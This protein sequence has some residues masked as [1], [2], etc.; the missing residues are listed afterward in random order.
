[1]KELLIQFIVPLTF[2]AIW[3]LTSILNRDGQPLPQRP[4]RPGDRPLDPAA[5]ARRQRERARAEREGEPWEADDASPS[6]APSRPDPRR[7][8]ATTPGR[9][10][11]SSKPNGGRPRPAPPQ[12]VPSGFDGAGVYVN[13]DEVVFLDPGTGRRLLSAPIEAEPSAEPRNPAAAPPRQRKAGRARREQRDGARQAPLEPETRRALSDQVGQAMGM[14]R[15]Q[16]LE[17]KPL[18]PKLE[19]LSVSLSKPV[20]LGDDH[21]PAA[22]PRPAIDAR[23]IQEMFAEARKLREV[24]VLSEILQPP[25]SLRRRRF[26]RDGR[27]GRGR[28]G[29]RPS[30]IARP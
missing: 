2:L 4:R 25:V 18:A 14:R 20:T 5:E 22:A 21:L 8:V 29:A 28:G 15:N 16:P 26:E 17:I 13:R 11:G 6:L 23:S 30:S 19:A 10:G 3:A 1:M 7:S 9:S 27:P 24:A 12:S